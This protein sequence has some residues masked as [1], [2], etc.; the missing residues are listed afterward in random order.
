MS[1]TPKLSNGEEVI[2]LDD[3]EPQIKIVPGAKNQAPIYYEDPGDYTAFVLDE[4]YSSESSE[5]ESLDSDSSSN[6]STID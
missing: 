6:S 5:S 4:N 2:P 3:D 1:G